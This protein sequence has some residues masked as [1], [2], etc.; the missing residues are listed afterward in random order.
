MNPLI[1]GAAVIGGILYLIQSDENKDSSESP[2]KDDEN[3]RKLKLLNNQEEIR[4]LRGQLR[5]A[6]RTKKSLIKSGNNEK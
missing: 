6:E 1:I 3:E 2:K 5:K 4:K